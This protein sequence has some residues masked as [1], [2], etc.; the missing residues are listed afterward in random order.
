MWDGSNPGFGLEGVADRP[1]GNVEEIFENQ[2]LTIVTC[3]LLGGGRECWGPSR[4][5]LLTAEKI[6]KNSLPRCAGQRVAPA[7]GVERPK[8]RQRLNI[9]CPNCPIPC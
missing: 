6:Q 5:E 4:R 9:N 3:R 2:I 1:G 8:K 7:V